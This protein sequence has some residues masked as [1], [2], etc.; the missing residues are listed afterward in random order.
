MAFTA[1]PGTLV[2]MHQS[3]AVTWRNG[4]SPIHSGKLELRAGGLS[5]EGMNG[6]GPVSLLIAYGELQGLRMAP[7]AERLDGRPTLVL[8]R[9]PGGDVR[10]ASIGAP[11]VISELTDHITALRAGSALAADRVAVVVPL[12]KGKREK[13]ER[14]LEQGPPFN[15]ERVGLERHE[16]FLTDN[17]ALFIFYAASGFGLQRLLSDTK[18]WASAAAWHDVV[19][20]PPR[21][22][23]PFFAW[24]AVADQDDLFF[25]ATPGPGDSDGGDIYSP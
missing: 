25:D 3:Y 2:N 23:K 7:G 4:D 22:A 11:G 1:R 9:R 5:L 16:V 10:V 15:P 19:A 12:R 14:L 21:I 13:A 17:E 20:G 24:A 8:G 6:A 18:V